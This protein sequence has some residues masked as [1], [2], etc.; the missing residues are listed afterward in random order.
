[1]AVTGC[2][3]FRVV[4]EL[5]RLEEVIGEG[6]R[7][8]IISDIVT[9]PQEKPNVADV[10]DFTVRTET[11]NTDIV[12]GKVI[13]EGALEL[14]IVYEAAVPPQTV[15]VAHFRLPFTAFVEI[16]GAEPGMTVTTRITV[17]DVNFEVV[18]GRQVRIRAIVGVFARVVRTA[19][20]NVVT[21]VT[22]VAGIV[23]TKETIRA[24]NVLGEATNQLVLRE[25]LVIPPEKPPAASVIDFSASAKV[26]EIEVITDKVIVSG[27]VTVRVIYEAAVPT[28][29]VHVAHFTIGFEG[30]VDIPGAREDMTVTAQVD[31]EFA[32]FDIAT[33][34]REIQANIV[35]KITAKV[36]QT[37]SIQVVTDVTGSTLIQVRKELVRIQEVLAERIEQSVIRQVVTVPEVKP[38]VATVLEATA[39][40]SIEE[41]TVVPGKVIVQGVIRLRVMYE[42]ANVTQTVNV[43]HFEIP[44]TDFVV[45]PEALP[46]MTVT[47]TAKVE[48]VS[49]EVVAPG[50]QLTAQIV[51]ALTARLVKTRQLLIVVDVTCGAVAP[52]CFITVNADRVN[53]RTGPGLQFDVIATLAR[54]TQ[55]E[56]IAVEGQWTRIR[57]ADGRIGFVFSELIINPCVGPPLG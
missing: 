36:V 56:F 34:G 8:T 6:T 57:L 15:H 4:R 28:Q 24:E 49:V 3:N 31:V 54:G 9:I 19:L 42:A 38:N 39:T 18:S 13:I 29:Q 35:L 40:V 48:F 7:Q 51:L 23:V 32:T 5:L 27:T 25:L 21:D 26:D 2:E 30:F 52:G 14:S 16:I 46:G 55:A 22:G 12:P 37:R 45:L 53:V 11:T 20:L 17:E 44:F 41:T 1:M 33:P 43:A 50:R 10:I 47:V